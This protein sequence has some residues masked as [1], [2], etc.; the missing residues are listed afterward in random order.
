MGST[1]MLLCTACGFQNLAGAEI[2][3]R[4]GGPLVDEHQYSPR[5]RLEQSVLYDR[6]DRLPLREPVC[7]QPET[8]AMEALRAMLA[9][10]TGCAL[11]IDQN[12][13]L[14]GIFTERDALMKVSEDL[15][16][17]GARPVAEFMTSPVQCLDSD[18]R[19][20]FAVHRMDVG[21][22]RHIPIRKNGRVI[23]VVSTREVFRHF[24]EIL[25]G[26]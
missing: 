6:I 2:C 26:V 10:R 14:V 3:S 15:E 5:N 12:G 16:G 20:A 18:V 11:V 4:C 17:R 9:Q 13:E 8:P 25:K 19:L 22:Y 24:T 1:K 21:G 23:G 7:V